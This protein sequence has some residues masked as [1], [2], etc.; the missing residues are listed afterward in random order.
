MLWHR[1]FWHQTLRQRISSPSYLI[2]YSWLRLRQGGI[3]ARYVNIF[4]TFM[5]SGL[6][7]VAEEY[8]TGVTLQQSGSMR[9]FCTQ[10]LGVMFEDTIQAVFHSLAGQRYRRWTKV[11]GYVW[12]A[13]WM[14][15]SSPAWLYPKLQNNQ[16]GERDKFLP[17]SLLGPLLL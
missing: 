13:L 14:V 5:V 1:C 6:L 15:W 16:G 4:L 11:V 2:T 3:V 8:G 17:F 9:F 10:V 7:H 12:F